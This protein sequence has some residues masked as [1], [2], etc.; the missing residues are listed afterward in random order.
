MNKVSPALSPASFVTVYTPHTNIP[1]SHGNA[2]LTELLIQGE[3][4]GAYSVQ[5]HALRERFNDMYYKF[6]EKLTV[7]SL[8]G[9]LSQSQQESLHSLFEELLEMRTILEKEPISTT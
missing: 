5:V 7:I 4:T 9:N 2:I 1:H 3:P 8:H 6:L